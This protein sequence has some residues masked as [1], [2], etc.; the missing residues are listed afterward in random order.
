[1]LLTKTQILLFNS[2]H[3][4]ILQILF[5]LTETISLEGASIQPLS[6]HLDI[7]LDKTV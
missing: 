7:I 6:K 2:I 1:M 3:Q 4:T 5:G